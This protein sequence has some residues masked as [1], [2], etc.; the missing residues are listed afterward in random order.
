VRDDKV[1]LTSQTQKRDGE[2]HQLSLWRYCGEASL[3]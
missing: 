2:E 3:N 1:S